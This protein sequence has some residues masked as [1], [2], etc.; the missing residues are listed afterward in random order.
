MEKG[1]LIPTQ[2]QTWEGNPVK[3]AW[4][5]AIQ[6]AL[7]WQEMHQGYPASRSGLRT[8]GILC[9]M[10]LQGAWAGCNRDGSRSMPK[11]SVLHCSHREALTHSLMF[12]GT[13]SMLKD[14][15]LP[16][17]AAPVGE[18]GTAKGGSEPALL[19]PGWDPGPSSISC[20]SQQVCWVRGDARKGAA[21]P[22]HV[23]VQV[24]R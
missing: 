1:S 22:R 17:P 13:A 21:V 8:L 18:R 15:F 9:S 24:G 20:P 4:L 16:L 14:A 3:R 11:V 7:W 19:Y 2:Q 23:A 10:Q 6:A 5:E 12:C